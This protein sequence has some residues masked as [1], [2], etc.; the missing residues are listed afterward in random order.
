MSD[1]S[2]FHPDNMRKRFHEL[3]KKRE[4]IMAKV[5]PLRAQHDKIVQEADAKAKALVSQFRKIEKDEG[6]F[7]LDMERAMLARALGGKTGKA[8]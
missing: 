8:T 7:D 2:A 1:K 6:L 4:A 3:G 5:G